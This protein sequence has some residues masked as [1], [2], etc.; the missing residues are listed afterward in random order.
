MKT[1]IY[2]TNIGEYN[3]YKT[4][5]SFKNGGKIRVLLK[6]EEGK[7]EG[8]VS[9]DCEENT[10]SSACVQRDITIE[11]RA[12]QNLYARFLRLSILEVNF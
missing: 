12:L 11:T 10:D 2:T 5:F 4:C 8:G 6:V 7:E 3:F 1:D 9:I